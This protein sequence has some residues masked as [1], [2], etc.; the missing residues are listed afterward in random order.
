MNYGLQEQEIKSLKLKVEA[1]TQQ[2]EKL[3]S[4]QKKMKKELDQ[5]KC[6]LRN[7][8]NS[9]RT[10]EKRCDVLQ[11]QTSRLKE[12][13]ASKVQDYHNLESVFQELEEANLVLSG[14]GTV[15]FVECYLNHC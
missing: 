9:Q 6:A 5:V 13:Y 12:R 2:V 8:T 14:T 4:A 10:A 1:C 11:K 15:C 3:T 7:V